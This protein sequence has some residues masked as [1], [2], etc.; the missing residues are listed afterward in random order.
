MMGEAVGGHQDLREFGS[1]TNSALE[2][3]LLTA[4][5]IPCI[6]PSSEADSTPDSDTSPDPNT[7]ADDK[8]AVGNPHRRRR[9][10]RRGRRSR[11]K[12]RK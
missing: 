10:R 6:V 4:P 9:G 5:T 1:G 12:N 8:P 2:E 3:L 11:N 7:S